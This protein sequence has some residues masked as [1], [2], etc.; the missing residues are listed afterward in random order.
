MCSLSDFHLPALR[1]GKHVRLLLPAH[2][3]GLRVRA[4][5]CSLQG[6]TLSR[7]C[8]P[9][10]KAYVC[11]RLPAHCK[12]I[13]VRLRLSAHCKGLRVRLRLPAHRKGLHVRTS[14]CPLQ[15]RVRGVCLHLPVSACIC[16]CLPVS[17]SI[18]MWWNS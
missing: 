18:G 11:A 7:V 13:L 16:L 3:K 8:L 10:A 6:P 4:S 12:G 14:A 1:K 17:A 9:I 5:A 2:C 15:G